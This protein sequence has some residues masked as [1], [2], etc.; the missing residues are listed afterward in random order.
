MN[1]PLDF[2]YWTLD[3]LLCII[4]PPTLGDLYTYV[5]GEE[6]HNGMFFNSFWVRQWAMTNISTLLVF[7]I[8]WHHGGSGVGC[9][10]VV[11]SMAK[12]DAMVG[13]D[14]LLN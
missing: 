2:G 10:R 14:H 7:T 5:E 9:R 1:C 4:C 11:T 8:L 6:A 13:F 3:R 12:I